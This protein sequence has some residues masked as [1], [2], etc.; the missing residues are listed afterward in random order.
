METKRKQKKKDRVVYVRPETI[1]MVLECHSNLL[2]S[3]MTG[4]RQYYGGNH[5]EEDW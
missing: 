1:L 5:D 2:A 3:S 4:N